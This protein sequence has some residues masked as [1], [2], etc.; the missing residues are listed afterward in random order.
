M[1]RNVKYSVRVECH[2]SGRAAQRYQGGLPKPCIRFIQD[3]SRAGT[4]MRELNTD[5]ILPRMV[6]KA[7]E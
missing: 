4:L 6:L 2:S 5:Y 1:M 3:S 7:I